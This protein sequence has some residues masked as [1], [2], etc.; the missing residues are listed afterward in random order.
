MAF[1]SIASLFTW[2]RPRRVPRLASPQT[3]V[4]HAAIGGMHSN[5]CVMTIKRQLEEIPGVVTVRV[6]SSPGLAAITF[7]AE[8]N[9]SDLQDALRPHGYTLKVVAQD[10]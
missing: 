8:I 1:P 5:T 4:L 2:V 3:A 7:R 6:Q 9:V 10:F